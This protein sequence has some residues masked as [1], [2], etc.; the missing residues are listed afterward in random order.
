MR[1]QKKTF[2]AKSKHKQ[3]GMIIK[4]SGKMDLKVVVTDKAGERQ[5]HFISLIK[6]LKIQNTKTLTNKGI[7]P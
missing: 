5:K 7:K 6:G 3:P 1:E 2:H 4:I